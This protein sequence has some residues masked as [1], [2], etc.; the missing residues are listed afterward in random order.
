[1]TNQESPQQITD[2]K[3]YYQAILECIKEVFSSI[4]SESNCCSDRKVSQR[5][6]E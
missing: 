4:K 3:E 6:D 1:M 5:R 2:L